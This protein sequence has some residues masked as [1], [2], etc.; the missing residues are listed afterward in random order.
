MISAP[1]AGDLQAYDIF[2]VRNKKK[3][4]ALAKAAGGQ[5]FVS[6]APVVLVFCSVPARSSWKYG[7]RGEQLYAIQDATI[8]AAYAQLAAT[9]LGLGCVW[10][11]AFDE[12]EVHEVLGQKAGLRAIVIMPI[13]YPAEKGE[14]TPRRRLEEL[15]HLI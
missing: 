2:V 14:E 15:V 3:K 11:G 7:S 4:Y 1:S 10:V 12:R 6:E 5:S 13:G 9:A 8:A